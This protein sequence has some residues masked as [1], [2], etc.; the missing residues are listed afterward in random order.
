MVI[1]YCITIYIYIYIHYS[2]DLLLFVIKLIIYFK[3]WDF[4]GFFLKI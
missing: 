1:L 4:K 3:K 2:Y